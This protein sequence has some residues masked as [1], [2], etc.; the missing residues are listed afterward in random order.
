MEATPL[1]WRPNGDQPGAHAG[2]I[3]LTEPALHPTEVRRPARPGRLGAG[4]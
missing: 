1:L 3:P 4:G 2:V